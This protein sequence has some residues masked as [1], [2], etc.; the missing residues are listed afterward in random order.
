MK[1]L[2]LITALL[3]L[4][5]FGQVYVLEWEVPDTR[6]NGHALAPEDIAGYVVVIDGVEVPVPGSRFTLQGTEQS[7]AVITVDTS[8]LRSQLSETINLVKPAA[9][10]GL[11]VVV[12]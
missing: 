8:G 12:Q 6:E 7:A 2:L 3:P 11:H 1:H 4:L 10:T 9:P 5:A